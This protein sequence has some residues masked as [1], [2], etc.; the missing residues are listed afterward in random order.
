MDILQE[1]PLIDGHNDFPYILR[2]WYGMNIHDPSFNIEEMPIGQTDLSRLEK[3]CIGGQFWSAFVPCPKENVDE[4]KL[5]V[6]RDTLQQ[7]DLIHQLIQQNPRRLAFGID[8]ASVWRA[9]H[10]RRISC[11][12]GVEGLHQ[13]GGSFSV[14]RLFHRMGVRYITLCHDCHNE[15]VDSSTPPTP[16]HYGLSKRGE[17]MVKEMNRIG[18]YA[19]QPHPRNVTDDVLEA[20][21]LNNGVIMI[22]FLPSLSGMLKAGHQTS[23]NVQTVAAHVMYVGEKIGYEYVGI[24]SDF[25]GML[26]G[27]AGLDDVSTFPKLVAELVANGI[28]EA[29]VKRIIGLNILRVLDEVGHYTAR[30]ECLPATGYGLWDEVQEIWTDVQRAMLI[31]KGSERRGN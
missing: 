27:P 13:I 23:A 5:A 30:E 29:D 6:L 11:L 9:F 2:G 4:T 28:S 19:L 21:K 25:D 12:I 15:F 3:G 26:E 14:L 20:L 17:D 8:S 18:I 22:C 10:S 1:V 24:G 31:R 16:L 7:I